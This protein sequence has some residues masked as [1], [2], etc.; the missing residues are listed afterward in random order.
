M[1]T[2]TRKVIFEKKVYSKQKGYQTKLAGLA[3]TKGEEGLEKTACTDEGNKHKKKQGRG[4][5]KKQT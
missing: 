1:Q 5:K 2:M 3:Q 4:A